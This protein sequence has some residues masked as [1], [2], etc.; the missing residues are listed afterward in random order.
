MPTVQRRAQ[1]GAM[2]ARRLA[3]RVADE[4][5]QG[6][7]AAGISQSTAA[8]AAGI[9]RSQLGRL[10]RAETSAPDL[11]QICRAARA[12][13]LQARI[14]LYPVGTPVR[15]AAHLALLKRFELRLGAPLTLRR[16]VPLPIEG[17]R[18]AW[19]A[20]IEG[21]GRP[22]FSEA[23]T[24]I[25]DVQAFERTVELKQRDDPRATVIILVATRSEH[26]RRVI[27]EHREALRG[28]FP[29]D[30]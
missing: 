4:L 21:S 8:R 3:S 20:M 7:V 9:S 2:D 10:E 18:R 16:E 22:F 24:H 15:D 25:H 5:R 30:G 12:L 11:D 6:R 28:L 29:L 17:D 1:L 19:D 14:R 27:G 13:G 26:N 23:E